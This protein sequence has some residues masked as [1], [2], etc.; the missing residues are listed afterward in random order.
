[1]QLSRSEHLASSPARST[2]SLD[3]WFTIT[4]EDLAVAAVDNS[5]DWDGDF[6]LVALP[7]DAEDAFVFDQ[8]R[9]EEI[10]I[11]ADQETE[12]GRAHTPPTRPDISTVAFEPTTDVLNAPSI[13]PASRVVLINDRVTP[14][15]GFNTLAALAFDDRWIGRD[16]K[17]TRS[18]KNWWACGCCRR[19]P[20]GPD[21]Y[22]LADVV[23]LQRRVVAVGRGQRRSSAFPPPLMIARIVDAAEELAYRLVREAVRGAHE[24]TTG[25]AIALL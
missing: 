14:A 18:A 3:E 2:A 7:P 8:P 17:V 12:K 13:L 24:R 20:R 15:P 21:S 19:R 22:P 10:P 9:G 11:L 25:T 1:M 16:A 4:R 6:Q 5:S 23:F